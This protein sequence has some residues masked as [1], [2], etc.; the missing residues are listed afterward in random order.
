MRYNLAMDRPA[1]IL[2]AS[3]VLLLVVAASAVAAPWSGPNGSR[4]PA[5]SSHQ[6]VPEGE[7]TDEE[8]GA[9]PSAEQLARLVERL[10]EAGI[11]T[12]A[13]TIA[14]L[15]ASYGLGGAIRV[16]AW[17]NAAAVDPAEITAMRD[18]GLGWGDIARQMNE[19][20]EGLD[21]HPGLGHILGQGGGHGRA[22]APGQLKKQEPAP[23][24]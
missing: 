1:R 8:E 21:L 17:S 10:G 22:N 15:A 20:Q 7:D 11:V 4:G 12:D 5:A 14:G 2:A 13:D 16:L 3:I 19:A 6:E 23:A 24:P 18:S 9:P